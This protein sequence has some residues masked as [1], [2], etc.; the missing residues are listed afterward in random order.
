MA[1]PVI[2]ENPGIYGLGTCNLGTSII[3]VNGDDGAC[4]NSASSTTGSG[5]NGA[6]TRGLPILV[7]HGAAGACHPGTFIITVS[8][9]NG[10]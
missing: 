2:G 3:K 9:N 10:A 5:Y 4:D 8:G 6:G 7:L 1:I